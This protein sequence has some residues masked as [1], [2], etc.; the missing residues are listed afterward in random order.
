MSGRYLWSAA[1]APCC[2]DR[3]RVA[4][5]VVIGL[6]SPLAGCSSKV[7]T[8]AAGGKVTL[9]DG[10]PLPAGFITFRSLDHPEHFAARGT[11]QSDGS[12]ELMTFTP[13]DG[14]V[15]GKHQ[16]LITT[17]APLDRP[18]FET[19]PTPQIDTRFSNYNTSG[20]EYTV[21]E[22]PKQNRFEIVVAP[23]R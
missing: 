6:C 22:D 17:P 16:V 21:T 5:L 8:H 20:L 7:P 10:S 2:L 11:I 13:G 1:G 3:I 23:G 12:F 19:P 4:I 18:G 9:G 14:A 15:V